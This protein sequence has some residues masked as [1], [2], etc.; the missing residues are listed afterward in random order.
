MYTL[1]GNW[2]LVGE[3]CP[4]AV[5]IGKSRKAQVERI[6]GILL[7]KIALIDAERFRNE[8][9]KLAQN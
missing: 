6:C 4:A 9:G 3:E 8:L 1:P 5:N 2:L 7:C